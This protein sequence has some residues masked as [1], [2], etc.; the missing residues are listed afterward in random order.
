MAVVSMKQFLEAGVHFGHQTKRW[1]PKMRPYVFGARNGIHIIDLQK[2]LRMLKVAYEYARDLSARGESILFVGTK[3]QAKE[4]VLEEAVRSNSFYINERWLG[5]LMTNFNTIKVSIGT[6]RR[7][8]EQRGEDGLYDGMIKKEALKLEKKLIKLKKALGGINDMR[9]MPGAIFV[10]D[11]K[12]EKIALL[13]AQKLKIPII[14][15][16][17][18]NCDPDNIDYVIPGNDDAIRAIRLFAMTIAD[19]V[20]EGRAI[21]EAHLR[22]Q[23]EE[24]PARR[25]TPAAAKP[26]AAAAQPPPREGADPA[27]APPSADAVAAPPP[28][29]ADAAAANAPA[30]TPETPA[31]TP[32]QPPP[33][34]SASAPEPAAAAQ[35]AEA[36]PAAAP[37]ATADG[38]AEAAPDTPGGAGPEAAVAKPE[39]PAPEAA[40]TPPVEKS[41]VEAAAGGDA[42]GKSG[43]GA[44]AGADTPSEK[45]DSPAAGA[46]PAAKPPE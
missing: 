30:A 41:T 43:G 9:R 29:A 5:G 8:E 28:V 37:E 32:A 6:M 11:C 18:T 17:D 36:A 12:K 14:A 45:P 4:I 39:K 35:P 33:A 46:D 15:V 16:V 31:A 22:S 38:G 13:E 10:I 26:D 23:P 2:T 1:N 44:G 19:A 3:Q 21:Y 40:T 42:G 27:A 25:I 24:K 20:L 34:A 7:L